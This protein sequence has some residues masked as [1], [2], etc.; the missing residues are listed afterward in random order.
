MSDTWQRLSAATAGMRRAPVSSHNSVTDYLSPF[1]IPE[2]FRQVR[3]QATG[4][5]TIEFRYPDEGEPTKEHKAKDNVVL[6]VGKV[7]MRLYSIRIPAALLQA[8]FEQAMNE[9]RARKEA[10]L[11]AI[12]QLGTTAAAG[13]NYRVAEQLFQSDLLEPVG[14]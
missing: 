8:I 7:S 11:R 1:Q 9:R 2:A 10:A 14:A 13:D 5:I 6:R 4:D 12:R 3:D